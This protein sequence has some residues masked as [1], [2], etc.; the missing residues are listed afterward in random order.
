M[1]GCSLRAKIQ[2]PWQP[3]RD[4]NLERISVCWATSSEWNFFWVEYLT[5]NRDEGFQLDVFLILFLLRFILCIQELLLAEEWAKKNNVKFPPIDAEEQFKK[6]GMKE[7]YVFQDPTDA[8][9]PIVMHFVMVNLTFREE[10]A[11]GK[12][13][14]KWLIQ[15]VLRNLLNVGNIQTQ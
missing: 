9:C 8:S 15:F 2:Q 14:L 6:H 11:P 5:P 12:N 7:L 1:N 13:L 3:A 10:S 4:P